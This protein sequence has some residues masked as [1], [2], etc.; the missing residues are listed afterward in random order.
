MSKL[1]LKIRKDGKTSVT[2]KAN[3]NDIIRIP[4]PDILPYEPNSDRARAWQVLCLMD[5]LTVRQGSEILKKLEYN[6]QG[7]N[8]HPL[9]WIGQAVT[10]Q[11]VEIH[12]GGGTAQ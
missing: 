11:Y 1:T 6:I 8:G 9:G 4:N 12:K 5:G 2:L 3:A 7:K 10:D